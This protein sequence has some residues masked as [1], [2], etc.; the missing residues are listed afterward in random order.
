MAVGGT[1]HRFTA[2]REGA[3][4]FS[5]VRYARGGLFSGTQF[6]SVLGTVTVISGSAV[7][8]RVL[9]YSWPRLRDKTH[10][11]GAVQCGIF[12]Y[13]YSCDNLASKW[14][15]L[16]QQLWFVTKKNVVLLAFNSRLA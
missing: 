6:W 7:A 13:S 9:L 11:L 16:Q 3:V 4:K 14:W 5:G 15:L 2:H 1:A 8:F 10:N 12:G